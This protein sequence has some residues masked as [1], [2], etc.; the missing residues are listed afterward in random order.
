MTYSSSPAA[1]P[2]GNDDGCW[3]ALAYPTQASA[4]VVVDCQGIRPD[5][6]G[7]EESNPCVSPRPMS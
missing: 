3:P 7:E 4:P 6:A 5:A 1:G 2:P